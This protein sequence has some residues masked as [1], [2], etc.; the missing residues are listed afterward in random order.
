MGAVAILLSRAGP[1][2]PDS[3]RRMLAAAPH[4]GDRAE[5]QALGKVVMGVCCDAAWR[6]AS[7]AG[8]QD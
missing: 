7:L 5:V 4:R 1:P 3:A 8:G 2:D 6:T